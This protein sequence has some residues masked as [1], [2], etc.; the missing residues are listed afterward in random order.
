MTRLYIITLLN[1]FSEYI[2]RNA[3][4]GDSEGIKAAG[5]NIAN[6]RYADDHSIG[7]K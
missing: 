2:M 5:R 6:F 7:R 3:R 4:L 1:F